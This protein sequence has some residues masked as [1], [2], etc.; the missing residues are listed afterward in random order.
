M[1]RIKNYK[2]TKDC[3]MATS[4]VQNQANSQ[5]FT[6]LL[7]GGNDPS[8]ESSETKT[9]SHLHQINPTDAPAAKLK[10]NFQWLR[11]CI[12]L[13]FTWTKIAIHHL[14][15][16]NLVTLKNNTYENP[17][18]KPK[19]LTQ[20]T[21]KALAT[22]LEHGLDYLK[23]VDNDNPNRCINAISQSQKLLIHELCHGEASDFL[24]NLIS[25]LQ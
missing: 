11:E 18:T 1:D 6:L 21:Y 17:F 16:F 9:T 15:P 22:T 23:A 19:A 5:R 3:I 12:S 10:S 2:S 13:G 14:L 8:T 7:A 25:I 24:L 20:D 4:Q